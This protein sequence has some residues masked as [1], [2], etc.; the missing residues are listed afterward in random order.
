MVS[1]VLSSG[2]Y[3]PVGDFYLQA[4]SVCFYMNSD[5]DLNQRPPYPTSYHGGLRKRQ[6]LC[7]MWVQKRNDLK[8]DARLLRHPQAFGGSQG[9]R[10]QQELFHCKGHDRAESS[11]KSRESLS[12]RVQGISVSQFSTKPP[13]D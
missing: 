9:A 13:S 6:I 3:F 7:I 12:A 4:V 10:S 11:L 1:G 5:N 8:Q 2:S